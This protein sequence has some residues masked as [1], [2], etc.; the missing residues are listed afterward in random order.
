MVSGLLLLELAVED[1]TL[2]LI[3]I[4]G[5]A[6]IAVVL[7]EWTMDLRLVRRTVALAKAHGTLPAVLSIVAA[8]DRGCLG[9][10]RA[11][12]AGNRQAPRE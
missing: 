11:P 7:L 5:T 12:G 4:G 3:S 10:L 2:A 6:A 1:K 9:G 8:L